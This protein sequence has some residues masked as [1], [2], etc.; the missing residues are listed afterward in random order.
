MVPRT[1]HFVVKGTRITQPITLELEPWASIKLVKDKLQDKVGIPADQQR[2][3]CGGIR[4]KDDRALL[5]YTV[6]DRSILYLSTKEA[7]DNSQKENTR[8]FVFSV[9]V[10]SIVFIGVS[11][12][13]TQRNRMITSTCLLA[14]GCVFSSL[15]IIVIAAGTLTD[16]ETVRKWHMQAF[17]VALTTNVVLITGTTVSVFVAGQDRSAYYWTQVSILSS[18]VLVNLLVSLRYLGEIRSR[19]SRANRVPPVDDNI[20]IQHNIVPLNSLRTSYTTSYN[21]ISI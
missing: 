8:R 13:E 16:N 9:Y 21:T 20:G 7:S 15:G 14:S 1:I 19:I 18:Y 2:L 4:M 5:D 10:M 6:H 17:W 11:V 12:Y 3:V